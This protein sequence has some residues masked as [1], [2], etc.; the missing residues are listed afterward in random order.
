MEAQ[1]I[2]GLKKIVGFDPSLARYGSCGQGES[3]EEAVPARRAQGW[4]GK[5]TL[6]VRQQGDG[7]NG[8]GD[9]Q[10]AIAEEKMGMEAHSQITG[11]ALSTHPSF[12]K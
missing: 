12:T 7:V 1:K 3:G 2:N 10:R 9:L 6:G 4:G 11:S 8:R 5:L